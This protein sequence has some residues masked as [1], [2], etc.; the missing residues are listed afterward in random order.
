MF[1]YSIEAKRRYVMLYDEVTHIN[2]YFYL[3]SIQ[4]KDRLKYSVEIDEELL[5]IRV[6]RFILQ[7]LVENS[8]THGLS[9]VS[10]GG[11]VKVHASRELDILHIT[12]EDNGAGMS[13]DKVKEVLEV[14]NRDFMESEDL[15]SKYLALNN[16]NKRLV[17]SYGREFSLGIESRPGTGTKV[18][19]RIPVDGF[20]G[21]SNHVQSLDR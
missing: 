2:N 10:S 20:S 18:T 12:V 9:S 19:I 17:M 15:S 13:G 8:V 4:H 7:P 5:S 16:V 1:R 14:I 21:G 6:P 11:E 3:L